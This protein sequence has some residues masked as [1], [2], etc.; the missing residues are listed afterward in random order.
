[1]TMKFGICWVLWIALTVVACGGNDDDDDND[2]GSEV[3]GICE[4]TAGPVAPTCWTY[5][6]PSANLSVVRGAC[7]SNFAG[8]WSETKS[9]SEEDVIGTCVTEG[10]GVGLV[11]ITFYEGAAGGASGA[12]EFCRESQDGE[13]TD[14]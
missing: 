6:G 7:A 2:S 1:M 10:G 3:L 14:R 8:A 5:E 11:T 4:V 12:K 9:C 13:W